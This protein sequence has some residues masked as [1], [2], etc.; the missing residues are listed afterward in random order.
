MSRAAKPIADAVGVTAPSQAVRRG[1]CLVAGLLTCIAL[2]G[3]GQ[4]ERIPRTTIA[5]DAKVLAIC[6]SLTNGAGAP[7]DQ[8]YPSVLAQRLG[9]EVIN[10]GVNGQT[11]SEARARLPELLDEHRPDL[12]IL[13]CGGNDFLR[14]RGDEQAEINLAAMLTT[15]DERD[16]PV[17]MMAVPAPALLGLDDHPMYRRLADRFNVP[18][19]PNLIADILSESELRSDRIHPNAEGYRKMADALAD[20]ILVI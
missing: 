19:I 14:K 6:D 2:L 1:R 17:I 12:V 4:S 8:S 3:C 5:D 7:R 15:L 18:L 13:I 16:I 20:A 10:A 9:V 11:S